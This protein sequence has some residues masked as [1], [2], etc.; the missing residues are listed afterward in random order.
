MTSHKDCE[1]TILE[2][3]TIIFV[4]KPSFFKS[5]VLANKEVEDVLF[6]WLVVKLWEVDINISICDEMA[7]ARVR[8]AVIN[9]VKQ[10]SIFPYITISLPY[11]NQLDGVPQ[12]FEIDLYAKNLPQILYDKEMYKNLYDNIML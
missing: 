12:H 9:A 8:E 3:G 2:D 11:L 1:F 5:S 4:E 6:L 7:V 10:L